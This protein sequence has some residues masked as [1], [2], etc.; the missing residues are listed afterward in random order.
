MKYFTGKFIYFAHDFGYICF[1]REYSV[2]KEKQY[3]TLSQKYEKIENEIISKCDIIQ[4]VGDCEF[5]IIKQKYENKTIRN[6]LLYIFDNKLTNIE[7]D[8]YERK[9]IIFVGGFMHYPNVDAVLWLAQEIYPTIIET[10][11]GV[12]M[13]IFG[14]K[15]NNKIK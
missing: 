6:F 2:I 10:F 13:C 11:P 14:G 7:K 12:I 5:N 4:V 3:L 1:Y 15:V 9:N 8:F